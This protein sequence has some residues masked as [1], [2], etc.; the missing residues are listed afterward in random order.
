MKQ[1]LS[2]KTKIKGWVQA[3]ICCK[4]PGFTASEVVVLL[5]LLSNK[6]STVHGFLYS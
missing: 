4:C 2:I 5:L 3:Q 1:I 6:S